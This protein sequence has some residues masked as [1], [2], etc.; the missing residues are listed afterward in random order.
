LQREKIA[1][2]DS[3]KALSISQSHGNGGEASWNA[4]DHSV[5]EVPM[6]SEQQADDSSICSELSDSLV[7]VLFVSLK[8]I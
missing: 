6:A 1:L 5:K 7:D 4:A 2:E 8:T 3:L